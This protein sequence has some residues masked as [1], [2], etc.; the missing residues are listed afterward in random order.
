MVSVARLAAALLCAVVS[1]AYAAE[2]AVATTGYLES[3][4]AFRDFTDYRFRDRVLSPLPESERLKFQG[5]RYFEPDLRLVLRARFEP[6]SDTATFAMPTYD[7]RTLSYA[8]YGTL[9]AELDGQRIRLQAF[10]R[11]DGESMRR[12]LLVPFRDATNGSETYAGGRYIEIDLPLP[13]VPQLDF[14]RSMNPLCAYDAS[15]ACPIPPPE[16]RLQLPIR[17][18]EKSYP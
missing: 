18:G 13:E 2:P 8:H 7:R 14:N 15:Y 4:A 10:R 3:L 12:F 9:V 17:A 5:L 11:A 6:A 16:N 1:T